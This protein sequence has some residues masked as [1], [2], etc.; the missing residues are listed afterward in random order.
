MPSTRKTTLETA[1]CR[2]ADRWELSRIKTIVGDQSVD[3]LSYEQGI[4][5]LNNLNW[6]PRPIF[7]SYSAYTPLLLEHNAQFFR[8]H[9][10]PAFVII[11]PQ[12]IDGR[13]PSAEDGEALEE[14]LWHYEPVTCE[15]GF[16]LLR[17]RP[18]PERRP[19]RLFGPCTITLGNDVE[20]THSPGECQTLYLTTRLTWLGHLMNSVYQIPKPTIELQFAGGAKR[21]FSG[22]PAMMEN[23]FLINPLLTDAVSLLGFFTTED[24]E[25]VTSFRINSL[26][27]WYFHENAELTVRTYP[28]PTS[29]R[30][31]VADVRRIAYPMMK[32]P[33]NSIAQTNMVSG[34]SERVQYAVDRIGETDVLLVPSGSEMR[35]ELTGPVQFEGRFGVLGGVSEARFVITWTSAH[36]E[37]EE[38]LDRHFTFGKDATDQTPQYFSVRVSDTTKGEVVCTVHYNE[39]VTGTGMGYWT[40]MNATTISGAG[41]GGRL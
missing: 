9:R 10:A 8:G 18:A 29:A 19:S 34:V 27:R 24:G 40:D 16:V 30:M 17:R 11:K 22:V 35:Y 7:Q 14:I 39:H 36:G 15:K 32:V 6:H 5:F 1:R 2:L 28:K 23:G 37:S 12:A 33:P 4:L 41:Y 3:L 21:Q 25:R 13:L 20:I 26:S 31:Q 38:L